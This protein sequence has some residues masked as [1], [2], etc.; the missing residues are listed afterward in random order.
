MDLVRSWSAKLQ[1]NVPFEASTGSFLQECDATPIDSIAN[2]A[3]EKGP[4][5]FFIA[6]SF[7]AARTV[8]DRAKVEQGNGKK[9]QKK[10]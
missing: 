3:A 2:R 10:K 1:L 7:F 6:K 9:S 4:R 8:A 5:E